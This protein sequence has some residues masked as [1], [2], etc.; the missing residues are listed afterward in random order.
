MSY[1][2]YTTEALVCGSYARQGAHKTLLLFTRDAGMLYA[3]ARSVREERSRQRGA[4]Q[5]FSRV[6]VSLIRGKAGWRVGSVVPLGNVYA[7]APDRAAR[8]SVVALVRFTRRFVAGEEAAPALFDELAAAL[9]AIS[10]RPAAAT[11]IE[12]LATVRLLLALGYVPTTAVPEAL[13]GTSYAAASFPLSE[14]TR[15]TLARLI[16]TATVQSQL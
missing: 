2:T 7:T 4:L 9:T 13:R 1:Q 10:T 15:A 8:G 14:P 5:D 12:L 3:V 16:D 11:D 6:R